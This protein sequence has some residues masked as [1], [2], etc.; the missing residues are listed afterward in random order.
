MYYTGPEDFSTITNPSGAHPYSGVRNE[1]T[2]LF[3]DDPDRLTHTISTKD[4]LNPIGEELTR[5]KAGG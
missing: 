5:V 1:S 4:A 3:Q 2:L